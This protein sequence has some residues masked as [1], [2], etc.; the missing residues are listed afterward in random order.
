[1][2][3]E[4]QPN[5]MLCFFCNDEHVLTDHKQHYFFENKL[6]SKLIE[7]NKQNENLENCIAESIVSYEQLKKNLDDLEKASL[8]PAEYL[9]DFFKNLKDK[10]DSKKAECDLMAS[11]I[12]SKMI[13]DLHIFET[14]CQSSLDIHQAATRH[15]PDMTYLKCRLN[16]LKHKILSL[17][18]NNTSADNLQSEIQV[19][20]SLV[21]TELTDLKAKLLLNMEFNF[22]GKNL[23]LESNIFGLFKME[24]P[25]VKKE[26]NILLKI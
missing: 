25:L 15:K 1:M 2:I 5:V 21:D 16:E 6:V 7:S 26:R 20:K 17:N 22:E 3:K 11:K 24:Y 8:N 12:H 19:L 10:I 23:N 13:K 18:V 14:E 4:S 9:H